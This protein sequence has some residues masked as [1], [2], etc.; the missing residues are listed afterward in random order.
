MEAEL[1]RTWMSE[2]EVRRAAVFARVV[3]R[4]W[5]LVEAKEGLWGRER[6]R[7]AH[8]RRRE[9][10]ESEKGA[11]E[12]YYRERKM[13]WRPIAEH[14]WRSAYAARNSQKP[15]P[16]PPR[17]WRR[18]RWPRPPLFLRSSALRP[19]QGCPPVRAS[20]RIPT[21]A[22]SKRQNKRQDQQQK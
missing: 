13:K 9:Q 22:Q 5:M 16:N 20:K 18:S 12:I 2:Q 10:Y 19:P 11:I 4:G 6:R 3:D 21:A 8:R 14:P 15:P 1:K 17:L 7:R